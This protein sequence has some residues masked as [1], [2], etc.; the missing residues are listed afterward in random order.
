MRDFG[1]ARTALIAVVWLGVLTMTAP[2]FAQQ[3]KPV[4]SASGT[5]ASPGPA[6]ASESATIGPEACK[7]C[8]EEIYN[9]WEKSP[10]WKTT[11]K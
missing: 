10:H 1:I 4:Q 5:A 7:T 9:S 11:Y 6:P 3:E 2:V 8:H